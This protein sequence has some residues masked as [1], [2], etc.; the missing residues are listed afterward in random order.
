MIKPIPILPSYT[1]GLP[2]ELWEIIFEKLVECAWEHLVIGPTMTSRYIQ[3]L[4]LV[5]KDA[6][7]ASARGYDHLSALLPY[8]LPISRGSSDMADADIEQV[9]YKPLAYLPSLEG[10]AKQL[11]IKVSRDI[12][13]A[14][15]ILGHFGLTRPLAQVPIPVFQAVYTE[16]SENMLIS[17]LT[18]SN[19]DRDLID[20]WCALQAKGHAPP[21]VTTLY[22]LRDAF[23]TENKRK[24]LIGA[25]NEVCK[26]RKQPRRNGTLFN[27]VHGTQEWKE[28]L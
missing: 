3:S 26:W 25:Y 16:L 12:R 6:Y 8:K 23:R 4:S 7:A 18:M 1:S 19:R 24:Q 20:I 27:Y 17:G 28:I 10:I 15:H 5:C 21:K 14:R 11:G 2:I 9:F 22:M 13:M